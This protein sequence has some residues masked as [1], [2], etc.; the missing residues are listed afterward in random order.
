MAK[1]IK[2]NNVQNI[3]TDGDVILTSPSNIGK[4]LD[5]V[6]NEQQSDINKLKSNVK[7]IYAYGGVGGSG[8]GGSGSTEKPIS[9]LITLN[10]VAV[11]NGG[12]AIILDGRGRYK[13]YVKIS[14][15]GGKNL[16][17]GYTTNGSTVTDN[18]MYYT[19]NGDN[20]YKTEIDVELN[21]NGI[22]NIAISDD[23]GNNIM[24]CSQEYI[25]DSDLFNVTLNYIDINGDVKQYTSEPYEC[26]VTDLNR[27]NRYFKIDYSIFLPEYDKESVNIECK[28]DGIGTIYTGSETVEIP[29]DSI[30]INDESFLQ[31]KYLGTYTLNATLSYKIVGRE[32]VR[33]RSFLFSIVPSDLYINVK[34]AGDVLYDDI[35]LLKEDIKNGK[36]GIP[37][38]HIS[39]G[40]SLMMY[41]KVFEG[42]MGGLPN[43]YTAIFNTFDMCVDENNTPLL[44]ENGNHIWSKLNIS[45][46]ES[47]TE[48]IESVK[49][50]SVTF[51]TS[52]I[53][54]I[55]ITTKHSKGEHINEDKVFEKFVYVKPFDS[56]CDW[57]DGGIY[58]VIMDSYFRANQG[59]DTYSKG[60]NGMNTFPTLSSGDG[61]F[62]LT[63]SS[64]PVELVQSN[65]GSITEN[66]CTVIT[67]GIQVSDINS[68]NAKIVDVYTTSSTTDAEYPLRTTR[69]FTSVD[70]EINKIAIP[71]EILNKND[72]SQYHLVQI[73]RNLS[74]TSSG[75]PVFEDCLYIDGLIESVDRSTSSISSIVKRIVL[76]N[77]NICY[78]L[79]NIQYFSPT[80]KNN[81]VTT[82]FN[83]DAYAYQYWLS[84]KEKY[85]NSGSNGERLTEGERIIKN[86]MKNIMFD[87]TNVVIDPKSTIIQD[88]ASISELPTVIFG[89]NCDDYSEKILSN[90]MELMWA[91]RSNGD[92]TDFGSR[93]IDLYWIPAGEGGGKNIDN[94]KIEIPSGLTDNTYNQNITGTWEIDLQGTSTLRNRIKNYSLRIKSKSQN[95]KDKI[96]FSPK[97]D[98]NDN[99]TFLPDIEW[100][101]KA[102]IADS[103]H[104]NNTSIGKFVNDVCTKIDTNIPDATAEAKSFVKNTLEG[105]PVL[106][107]FMC[108]GLN[109]EGTEVITKIYYFG[110]YNF[111]L[112]RN[113]YY[114]L[115]Y[116][117][118]IV[119]TQEK[120]SDFMRVYYNIL[121]KNGSKYFKGK[122]FTFAV[123]EGVL[124]PNIAV[125]EIQDNYPEF[126]FHQFDSSLLFKT[127][128]GNNACM[129][130]A[131][132]K[133][134][135]VDTDNA[136]KALQSLVKGVAKAGKFCFGKVGRENDFV[137]SREFERDANGNPVY[138]EDGKIKYGKGCINRYNEKKI[139]HPI[140]QKKYTNISDSLGNNVDWYET[141]EDFDNVSDIDLKKLITTY[142]LEDG[143]KNKPILNYTSASEYYTIC[144]AFGMV[145]SVLKNMNLKNFR[146]EAEGYNFNCAFYDMDCALEE[147]ND[148]EEKISYLAAT[149]YW[150]SPVIDERTNKIG[151]IV[152]ENDYW[153][154]AEGGKGFD[155]TSSYLFSVIKYA[156]PIFESLPD[157]E[158]KYE[159]NLNHYPQNFWATLRN[160]EGALRSADHFINNYF[161]S[162]ITSTYEYLASL[163]YR[164]KYLYHGKTF[165]SND[166]PIDQYLANASAFNGSRRIKVKNWLTKRLRFMDVM[167][168]VNNLEVPVYNDMSLLIPG[169]GANYKDKLIDNNDITILHSA[170]DSNQFNTALSNFSGEV[171]IYAP[172]HTPFIFRTGSDHAKI[173]LL[174]GG[175]DRPNLISYENIG[176]SIAAR[177]Y[178]SG[179]F[180]SVDKIESMFTQYKSIISDNIEK[181]IYGGSKV[182]NYS[183]GFTIDAKSLTEIKLDIENMG[184]ELKI[185]DRCISLNKINIAK[186]GFYGSFKNFSNLQYVDISSVNAPNNSIIVAG[187]NFLKGEKFNI[188]GSDEKHKTS[189]NLLDVSDVTGNFIFTNTNIEEIN[190]KNNSKWDDEDSDTF[191]DSDFD[192]SLLSEFTIYRDTRLKALS[193]VGFRKVR[194][195]GC[196]N[197]E[198]LSIDGA[199]EELEIDLVKGKDETESKLEKIF[200]GTS[201]ENGVFDFTNY[202][203]LKRV[204]LKN[205]DK[206][207]HIKLPDSNIETDGMS[208]NPKLKWI[209]TGRLPAF[210]DN[211][212]V[213]P[214]ND[215]LIPGI[216]GVEYPIYPNGFK[217]VL[218]KDGVFQNCPNY[219]MVRSD[220][221]K[222]SEYLGNNINSIAYTNITVSEKC[223]SLANTFYMSG[224]SSNSTTDHKFNMDTVIRFLK[225]CVPDT[226][227]K[228]ITSLSGCFKGRKDVSYTKT[229]A[230]SYVS[231]NGYY[232]YCPN[233]SE[234]ISLNDIS[235][236]YENTGVIFISK[237]LL[238]LPF[239]DEYNT[240]ENILSWGSFIKQNMSSGVDVSIDAL[241][242]ISY[243]LESYS[244]IKFNIYEYDITSTQYKLANNFNICDFFYHTTKDGVILPYTNIT[245]IS[246]L[247]F[248]DQ[249]I[250]FRGMFN[251]FPNVK[252]ISNFLN[253]NLVKYNI[254]G[255]LKPCTEIISIINSFNDD[256][257]N[258][259]G[260]VIDLY[261]FFNWEKNT[262]DITNL[263]EGQTNNNITN[264]FR[265]NKTVTYTNF[266]KI[267]NKISDYSNLTRL[268]NIFSY[269]TIT[270]YKDVT[271][272]EREIKF[273]KSLDNIKNIS[274]LFENCTSDYKPLV[275]VDSGDKGI[276]TGGVLNIGR[277]FFEKLPKFT[278]A[279]RTFANTYLSTPLTYDYFCKRGKNYKMTNV[280]LSKDQSDIA[281][282]YEYN[283]SSDILNLKECFSNTK[284]VNCKNWFDESDNVTIDRNY[285]ELSNGVKHDEMG[286][287]YYKY[288]NISGSYEKYMIDNDVI[289]DCL[290]NYTD[291]IYINDIQPYTWYNHDLAQDFAYY[292]NLKDGVKPFDPTNETQNTIQETYCCLP[293]DFL[294]GCSNTAVIDSIFANSNIT[295]VIPRNLTKKIKKQ[296]IPNIFKNVN[297]MP[298][299]EYYYDGQNNDDGGLNGILN[300]I[301]D[302]V[303]IYDGSDSDDDIISNNYTVIFRDENGRLKKRKPVRSD[304][305]LGQFV[306]VPA[307]FTTSRSLSNTFNFRYNLPK[308]WGMPNKPNG[309]TIDGYKSTKEFNDANLELTYHTQYFFTT[310]KSVNWE[311]INNA[312]SVFITNSEDIDFS[313][314]I[315]MGKERVYCDASMDV[316]S[317]YK[318]TWTLDYSES[319]T[320]GWNNSDIIKKF[321]VDLNLCG[322]KNAYN[323][324]EDYGCPIIIK[325]REV[326]LDN[327]VS[328]ILTIFLN[329]RV[330]D[331][332]FAIN[333]L[334]TS[335]HKD[336]GSSY[337]IGYHGFGKNIILPKYS[338]SPLDEDFVFIPI[339]KTNVIY[340]DFMINDN[341]YQSIDNYRKY[342]GERLIINVDKNKYT[343]K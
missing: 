330:F 109:N 336:S 118:G 125:G 171:A 178:G 80:Y 176:E 324:I 51:S 56:K 309:V 316:D 157:T 224:T 200:L 94:F 39:Q 322:K 4:T 206:L 31:D 49:G 101:I 151:E 204:T 52:G 263:F 15:A 239:G 213:P 304:K 329:G 78:N 291:F 148:G 228:K 159:S 328:G 89:Y 288:N 75:T 232:D 60:D 18:L 50:V 189:L 105:I 150:Y 2:G 208:N 196:N 187:S 199:L 63:T 185:S 295:G 123:G 221:D 318:N 135:A 276:Y 245:S 35:E 270:G 32:V 91:G 108:K 290:Y 169:P 145:D 202:P 246:S 173:Y 55:T 319:I 209:D 269:C 121:D 59:D 144:M 111:N 82:K 259:G 223:T 273:E 19:L 335:N 27:K 38:K 40:S 281:T 6:L 299:L 243:R 48:Q 301:T 28:I 44:D 289:D 92:N 312:K 70:S 307:N 279:E 47:L 158:E 22:L 230:A 11:N 180:T 271:E 340:Y 226:V 90:F 155:F 30:I 7:Y 33:T 5:E 339:D 131:D 215:G 285:I 297:I 248:A 184:G 153:N 68:E 182:S 227:K 96:L 81:G 292:G 294:Y 308:H 42:V 305:N 250:D 338:G 149:D 20:K 103:A 327:F 237:Q 29:L 333:E 325:N 62:S 222:S 8:S 323:M 41:C 268:T 274:F 23:E 53:K 12:S 249:Y 190:I 265:I 162:G 175:V 93:K 10:G 258:S 72:N 74:D 217:L 296:S 212:N 203:N 229:D 133:I 97:F 112:G 183:D 332:N 146:S 16:F 337:V 143:T 210:L 282:L 262:P 320:S 272:E 113:S 58:D 261:N 102:D 287:E 84:Y 286:F 255:L 266:K 342:F 194:I 45:E 236:M 278:I 244:G 154:S 88:I 124:N 130:G 73:I 193:L 165:D 225:I 170:F 107:Y 174:P 216:N 298:N 13:L 14:N 253:G 186:S 9:V 219:N 83:P 137:T 64:K 142:T 71:T 334:T 251:L 76:N 267:L 104:A 43:S 220:W 136:K 147:A 313:N 34:T 166:K 87:G 126:D 302:T 179:L 1:L 247:N 127:T 191:Y 234:Y 317:K 117:G 214:K 79:I 116:T 233:L 201:V 120:R 115:G 36:D 85:V 114:N 167:M 168:N 26:F 138:G 192:T 238:S 277:S 207:V 134:T 257:V 254:D 3:I 321:Y 264:G 77:I 311:S 54:K 195:Y 65:W 188:S 128:N 46:S 198:T 122:V 231:T 119:D 205:C 280:L 240:Y 67:F 160:S 141:E 235:G 21:G 24:Y 100:T 163:N 252:N 69:L 17:M 129:F 197:L 57:F 315:V 132:S 61:V 331:K 211:D 99:K 326:Q 177:F 140:W 343:F 293:P 106:L 283:Y 86:N 37:Y 152:K 314:T 303:E 156:K 139:P 256:Y 300:Y 241:E 181:I 66:V 172:K 341:E 98:I 161:K 95:D 275:N 242:N 260:Q 310:D 164:V 110:I 306:Y 25:V 284:F 218:C